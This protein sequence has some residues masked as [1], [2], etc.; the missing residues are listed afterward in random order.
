MIRKY[1]LYLL[2]FFMAAGLA[3]CGES[4][5]KRN[6]RNEINELIS[7]Y[8]SK[9]NELEGL[10][11]DLD[12]NP[13]NV[14]PIAERL[15]TLRLV[16]EGIYDGYIVL[17]IIDL[18]DEVIVDQDVLYRNHETLLDLL[19]RDFSAK[20][21]ANDEGLALI[22]VG[23]TFVDQN[24]RLAVYRA[25]SLIQN[26]ESSSYA[27]GDVITI[28]NENIA[29]L[30]KTD[31]HVD[32]VVY[33]FLR[34]RIPGYFALAPNLDAY[35]VSALRL[36]EG[37]GYGVS[38]EQIALSSRYQSYYARKVYDITSPN[39]LSALCKDL[40]IM[41]ALDLD[42]SDLSGKILD[43]TS[44]MPYVQRLSALLSL[45]VSGTPLVDIA[46]LLDSI[47]NFNPTNKETDLISLALMALANYPDYVYY[48]R[49]LNRFNEFL[50]ERM[51]DKG[52]T[53]N[54]ANCTSTAGA[55]IAL[56]ANGVDPRGTQYR[57]GDA[58]LITALLFYEHGG[59]FYWTPSAGE[60]LAFST[61]QAWA[62]LVTYKISRDWGLSSLKLFKP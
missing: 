14:Y 42:V 53:Q 55:V 56:L 22:S 9:R 38:V 24:Y 28:R 3:G 25:N 26:L 7:L 19:S 40:L 18:T 39:Y 50:R 43:R 10:R 46:H 36:L 32:R 54:G 6:L 1:I 59:I 60:D 30:S 57:V 48:E 51:S 52:I 33:H 31:L 37:Y 35:I 41:K 45:G 27:Y 62:A 29:N 21:N 8:P 44:G 20:Y 5:Q 2:V 16:Y 47:N 15:K 13:N 61:P 58:D 12:E 23:G 34:N 17:R 49:N 11:N 4:V